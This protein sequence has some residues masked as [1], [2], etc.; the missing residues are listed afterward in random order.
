MERIKEAVTQ[1]IESCE[2]QNAELRKL[3]VKENPIII[4]PWSIRFTLGLPEEKLHDVYK[5]MLKDERLI[6][7][8]TV[9]DIKTFLY[10]SIDK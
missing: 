7:Q 8:E 3:G 1:L 4:S 6:P 2:N 10:K 9:H 5:E